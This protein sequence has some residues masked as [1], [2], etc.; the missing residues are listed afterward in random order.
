MQNNGGR[1]DYYDVPA[2]AETLADLIEHKD[3]PFWRGEIF[4][5]C[6]R[7]GGKDNTT[8]IRELNKIIYNATRRLHVLETIKENDERILI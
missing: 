7:I 1:T 5:A 2:G 8:E 4:K 6:Y 3:M